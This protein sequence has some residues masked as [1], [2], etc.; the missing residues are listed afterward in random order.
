MEFLHKILER[1]ATRFADKGVIYHK[2]TCIS[3]EELNDRVKHL[4]DYL[5]SIGI[6]KGDRIGIYATKSI[7]EI[8]II[9]AVM[10]V[11]GIF[12]HINPSFKRGQVN[13][14]I[15]DCD[16]KYLF[17]S[18]SKKRILDQLELKLITIH[19]EIVINDNI[20][21]PKFTVLKHQLT[22]PE[23]LNPSDPAAIIYTSGSTGFP[24]GVIV[25]HQIFYDATLSSAH[26]LENDAT[27]ILLSVTP[28]SFDGAL[29]QLFTMILVGGK[30]VLQSSLFPNDI[31]KSI[32]KYKITGIH[33]VPS[34][35]K[36]LRLNHSTFD[37]H[38]YKHLRYISIIG[39]IFTQHD[40]TYLKKI[41]RNTK[42]YV[43]YGITEAF[44]STYFIP[45]ECY[46]KIDSVGKP[47]EGVHIDI[48][49]NQ[50][51]ICEVGEVGEIVH[52]GL[53]VSPGYWNNLEKTREVFRDGAL[54]TG[55]L[56]YLDR[57]GYLYF[58]GR[59]D[60]MFKCLG[61]R[62]SPDEI[63]QCINT[64]PSVKESVAIQFSDD[65]VENKIKV[66]VVLKGKMKLNHQELTNYCK[67]HL[68]YYMLPH[69]VQFV[70]E[71]PRTSTFKIDRYQLANTK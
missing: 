7:E 20:D 61:Y 67:Q 53:F 16:M 22:A 42:I 44:R 13:H 58:H 39:E 48:V 38:E 62:I 12:V 57:D 14:V 19:T 40:F 17:F 36:M 52:R 33:G 27:D 11:G 47:I 60:L 31:I 10:K 56:G 6:H 45:E 46:T 35:W 5:K 51:E 66:Y 32:E 41:L 3:Y 63:E 69:V 29:S 64:I 59:K 8:I 71:I 43:M 9:F 37:K 65:K 18:S 34:F 24:K 1:S 25:T 70:E 54:F 28:F 15:N 49:N 26:F 55:D 4:A 21:N 50:G 30:L 68:P 2:D 23:H